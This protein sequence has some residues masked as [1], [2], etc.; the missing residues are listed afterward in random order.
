[1]GIRLQLM[2]F[3]ILRFE[4]I[5][6]TND[7]AIRQARLGGDEGLCVFA[8][9]QSQGRGRHGRNWLSPPD[10]GIYFSLVLRPRI[11]QKNWAILT[12]LTAIAVN[13]AISESCNLSTDIK[14]ANDIHS[15]SGKKLAG[16]LAETCETPKGNAVIVGI[17]I[18]LKAANFP[19]EIAETATSIQSETGFVPDS[20]TLLQSLTK[21][22]AIYYEILHQSN[23]NDRII[24]EW[25]RRSSYGYG[26][27]VKVI[28]PDE[29][30]IGETRGLQ[31]DGA[32]RLETPSGEIR[33][34]HA[35][36]IVT[37]RK[38]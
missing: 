4:T 10:A 32:L 22:F 1:M 19:P 3:N 13:E 23:D 18:N 35:G 24:D 28:L 37:L 9:Q 11:E 5:G 7:E 16:I 2:N 12:L 15:V 8:R 21:Y 25:M 36:E 27:T 38:N 26:K 20:E 6:S 31:A 14:W 17:G 34:V 29:T 33:L 30:I